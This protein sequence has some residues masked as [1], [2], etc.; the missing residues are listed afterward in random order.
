MNVINAEKGKQIREAIFKYIIDYIKAHGYAPTQNEM[1]E[2]FSM[3]KST[4]NHHIMRMFKDGIIESDEP[5]AARAIRV[6]GYK[7]EKE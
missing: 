4:M 6:P 5:G 3:G 1:R 7:F 2:E